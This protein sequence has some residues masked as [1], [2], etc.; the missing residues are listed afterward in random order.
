MYK[1]G[2]TRKRGQNL[3]LFCIFYESSAE[4]LHAAAFVYS[5]T[6]PRFYLLK[7]SDHAVRIYNSGN[8]LL[9]CYY[10]CSL[11]I[12]FCHNTTPNEYCCSFADAILVNYFTHDP[13]LYL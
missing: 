1:R 7:G 12:M 5:C 10:F 3:A 13:L 11:A 6:T 9:T 2:D 4:T 8:F